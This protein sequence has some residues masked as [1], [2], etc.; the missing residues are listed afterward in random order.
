MVVALLGTTTIF[1]QGFG[2]GLDYMMLSGTMIT[3]ADGNALTFMAEDAVE[4][5]DAKEVSSSSAVLNL[6]Y[7]HPLSE[8]LDMVGSLGYGMGFG[9]IPMKASL[10]YG[11]SSNMS[12]N[13]GMGLYMI[14]DDS[15]VPTG[16]ADGANAD[17]YVGADPGATG[18]TNELG[19]SLGVKYHMNAIGMGLGYDM[20]KG[21]DHSSLNAFTIN[22]SY[23]F[24]GNSSDEGDTKE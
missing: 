21:G 1:A 18:S 4:G 6:S 20:I 11:I 16:Y 13:F 10:S 12:A 17:G 23:S 7:T 9:L 14:T 24:G 8:K 19:M 15:Y 2:L 3:D 5:D 22:L